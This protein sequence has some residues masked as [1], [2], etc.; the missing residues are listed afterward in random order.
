MTTDAL[1]A[2]PDSVLDFDS[3]L[4]LVDVSVVREGRK[5]LDAVNW[6]VG[7]GERWVLLGPNGAGKTTVLNIAATSMFPTAGAVA[8]LGERLGA[9]DV[10][11]LRPRIGYSSA[12]VAERLPRAETVRDVVMTASYGMVGRWREKYDAADAQR[13]EEL[14]AWWGMAEFGGRTFGTLSEGERKRALIA[15]ALM[16]DPELLLLDEP[17]A[18]LDLGG[19][20]DLVRRLSR[21]A[22]DPYAPVTVLVTHHVEEIP[23]GFSHIML[24]RAGAVVAA[25]PVDGTLTSENLT[26]TFGLPLS[27][28]KYATA[29]GDRWYARAV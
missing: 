8:V 24:V 28:E 12:A 6:T 2:D 26:A 29:A 22:S 21:L 1:S 14:L 23:P 9:V 7:D 18:G 4:D 15:R 13:A 25:G 11:E 3:V 27:V 10:F 19:R 20:E 17:A 16:A 5:L